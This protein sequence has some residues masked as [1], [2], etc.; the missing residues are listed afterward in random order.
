ML[1]YLLAIALLMAPAA[2]RAATIPVATPA[3]LQAAW[4]AAKPGD[5]ILLAPGNYGAVPINDAQYDG[6]VTVKSAD[7]KRPA[8]FTRATLNS[9]RNLTLSGLEFAYV[10]PPGETVTQPMV[11]INN[12]SNITLDGVYVHGV[13]DGNVAPDAHGVIAAGV[14]GLTIANSRF[15]EINIGIGVSSSRNVTIRNNDISMIGIDAIEIPGVD[16]ALIA[17]NRMSKW[18]TVGGFHPDG[19]QCWTT[20][21]PAAC[22]NIRI[23]SNQFLGDANPASPYLYPQGIWFGDEMNRGDYTNI[24]I[25]GNYMRCVNWHAISMY[26]TQARGT[27]V[28]FNRIEACPGVTP[29]IKINDPGAVVE[30]NVA[31]VY[32]VNTTVNRAPAGNAIGGVAGQ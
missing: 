27:V 4:K 29:W 11:R 22:K 1:R 5:T 10:P 15:L 30:G 28:K 17:W 21:M 14:D 8:M 20:G 16:G 32:F 6:T 13:I 24:E 9:A 19:I 2:A 26:V 25:V 3:Q 7:P 12:G 18:R 31:P 23:I